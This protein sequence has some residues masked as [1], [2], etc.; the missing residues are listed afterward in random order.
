MRNN[1]NQG[2]A[3]PRRVDSVPR[4]SEVTGGQMDQNGVYR[5]NRQFIIS[6]SAVKDISVWF[7]SRLSV[8][9]TVN[10]PEKIIVS[11]ARVPEFKR[12]LQS[13]QP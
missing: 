4:V 11:K 6:R 13:V 8:N 7:G 9:M 2:T 12:W 3:Q 5:A 10:T 1:Y